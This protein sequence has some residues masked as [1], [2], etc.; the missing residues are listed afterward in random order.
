MQDSLSF[1]NKLLK[2]TLNEDYYYRKKFHYYVSH[3]YKIKKY[4]K[5]LQPVS[6]IVIY[7]AQHQN[8]DE[9][10]EWTDKQSAI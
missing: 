8:Q 3:V 5:I 6:C 9:S 4:Y 7:H 1:S 10:G 2:I